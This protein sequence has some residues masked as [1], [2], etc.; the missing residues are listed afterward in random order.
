MPKAE[1][2]PL[3]IEINDKLDV[4]IKAA[5]IDPNGLGK[6]INPENSETQK[7]SQDGNQ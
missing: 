6:K 1:L 5:K 3:L 4:I 7:N 2:K